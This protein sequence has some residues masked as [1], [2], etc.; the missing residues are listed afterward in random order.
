MSDALL[1]APTGDIVQIN[2]PSGTRDQLTVMYSV[3]RCR[4]VAC[5]GVSSSIHMWVDDEGLY[6][7]TDE[8]NFPAVFFLSNF[9]QVVQPIYGPVL[10]TGG[11]DEE[12]DTLPLSRDKL[13]AI[14][15]KLEDGDQAIR[16]AFGM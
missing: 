2:L 11:S 7:H 14:L 9:G 16:Q 3:L 13:A 4:N 6:S 15:S 8:P 1:I 12:G 5:V 10:L